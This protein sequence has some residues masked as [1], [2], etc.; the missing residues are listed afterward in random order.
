[1]KSFMHYFMLRLLSVSILIL[2]SILFVSMVEPSAFGVWFSSLSLFKQMAVRFPVLL[3]VIV[4]SLL[5]NRGVDIH[6]KR[7]MN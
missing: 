2:T 5:L 1:M 7:Y 6:L 3:V 4:L